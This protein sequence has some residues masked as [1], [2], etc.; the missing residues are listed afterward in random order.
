MT[1][2]DH[3]TNG[4]TNSMSKKQIQTSITSLRVVQEIKYLPY[5]SIVYFFEMIK[6]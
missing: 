6:T 3:A 2:N 1:I 5:Y 4:N